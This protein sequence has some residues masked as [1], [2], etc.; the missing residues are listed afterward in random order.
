MRRGDVFPVSM[1]GQS[2][3]PRPGVII[4]ATSL[5]IPEGPILVCPL[6]SRLLP[7]MITRPTVEPSQSNGLLVPSQPMVNRMTS[8]SPREIGSIIGCLSQDDLQ[9]LDLALI[10]ILE[11]GP[12]FFAA[13]PTGEAS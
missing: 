13:P 10:I 5:I 3:K 2:K 12:A 7:D 4:Q 6:T 9:R 11:L 1:G 8:A